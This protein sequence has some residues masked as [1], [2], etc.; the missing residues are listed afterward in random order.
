MSIVYL[1]VDQEPIL[2]GGYE[3]L[4]IAAFS[5]RDLAENAAT[6][7]EKSNPDFNL[8]IKEIHFDPTIEPQ[9]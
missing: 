6:T 1:L 4:P 7:W 5:T 8:H 9:S 3:E 2:S